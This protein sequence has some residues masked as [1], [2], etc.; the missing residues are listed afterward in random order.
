MVY[1]DVDEFEDIEYCKIVDEGELEF[2]DN[3]AIAKVWVNHTNSQGG[4]LCYGTY[5]IVRRV[6]DN[7][8]GQEARY[9]LADGINQDFKLAQYVKSI[10]RAGNHFIF[11]VRN[12]IHEEST[13]WSEYYHYEYDKETDSFINNGKLDGI[14]TMTKNDGIV[15]INNSK[16]YSLN[17]KGYIGDEHTNIEDVDGNNFFIYDDITTSSPSSLHNHLMCIMTAVGV[18]ISAVYSANL[19]TWTADDIDVPYEE[20][21]KHEIEKLDAKLAEEEKHKK[22]LKLISIKEQ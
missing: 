11:E 17:T 21:K 2:K 22:F 12:G 4:E 8:M 9:E 14:P 16:M 18:K 13:E 1:L 15:I 10:T 3:L 20:I 6:S 5:T 19:K 7:L